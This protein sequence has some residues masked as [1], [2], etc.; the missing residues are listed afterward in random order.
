MDAWIMRLQNTLRMREST[1][2]QGAWLSWRHQ[3]GK[4]RI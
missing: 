2:F 4:I 3:M 1:G